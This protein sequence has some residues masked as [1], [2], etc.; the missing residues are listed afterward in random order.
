MVY[1]FNRRLRRLGLAPRGY[2]RSTPA[3]QLKYQTVRVTSKPGR[4][5]H[6]GE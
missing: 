1:Q 2:G 5:L 3:D 4:M 6:R